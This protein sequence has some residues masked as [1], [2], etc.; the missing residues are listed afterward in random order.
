[1]NQ[2]PC[3]SEDSIL[4]KIGEWVSYGNETLDDPQGFPRHP[5]YVYRLSR[6]WKGWSHFLGVQQDAPSYEENL[7]ADTVEDQAFKR[8]TSFVEGL[9]N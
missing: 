1:M 5:E 7:Q 8:L 6:E 3:S 9:S 4:K 2:G